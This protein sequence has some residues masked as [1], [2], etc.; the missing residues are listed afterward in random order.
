MH[1]TATFIKRDLSG[2]VVL[3][4]TGETAH[5]FNGFVTLEGIGNFIWE[6]IE[7]S[8]SLDHLVDMIVST[9]EIDRATAGGDALTLI[10]QLLRCGFLR[11]DGK[12]W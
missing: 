8:T 6:H 3:I 2:E 4:P 7:E 5:R 10:M 9:Y 11:P 1:K 12:D